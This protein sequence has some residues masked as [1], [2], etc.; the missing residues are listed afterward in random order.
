M[1]GIVITW[2]GGVLRIFF[3]ME[4]FLYSQGN[5][6]HVMAT[7]TTTIELATRDKTVLDA[8][9]GDLVADANSRGRSAWRDRVRLETSQLRWGY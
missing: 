2:Q 9:R 8:V 7:A 3:T 5:N 1:L 6:G 4:F